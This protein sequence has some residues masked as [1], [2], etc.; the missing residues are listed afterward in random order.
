MDYLLTALAILL[1]INI[2]CVNILKYLRI[3]NLETRYVYRAMHSTFL[4]NTMRLFTILLMTREN[5]NSS[6]SLCLSNSFMSLRTLQ[7]IEIYLLY[8]V[9]KTRFTMILIPRKQSNPV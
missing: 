6:L 7:S 2:I 4:K 5:L 8:K 9:S 3:V 1:S